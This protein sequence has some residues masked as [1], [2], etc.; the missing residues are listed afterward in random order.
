MPRPYICHNS[1]PISKDELAERASTEGS[2]IL[3]L[4]SAAFYTSTP[5]PVQILTLTPGPTGIYT[6][7]NLQKTIRLTLKSF[8]RKQEHDLL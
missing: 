8:I 7:I 2:S 1:T 6:D 3:T 5:A 4:I